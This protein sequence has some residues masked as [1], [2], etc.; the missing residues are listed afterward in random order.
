M[1]NILYGKW[2]VIMNFD[3]YKSYIETSFK[4]YTDAYDSSDTKIKLKIEHTYR[5]ANLCE[6]I[7]E[8]IG[9]N[10]KD[11]LL[12]WTCGM[13]H[14]I[15]RFEQVKR[16]GTFFDSQSVD[17]AQFGADLLFED[18]LYDRLVPWNIYDNQ[19]VIVE[20]AI[21]VHNM[22]IIPADMD[23]R[24]KMFANILRDA[25]KIDILKVNCDN[26]VN[27]VYNRPMEEFKTSFVSDDVKKA[28]N[29]KH[30][31][32]RNE[33]TSAIDFLVG[34]ICLVFELVFPMSLVIAHEQGYIY[35][36]L[37]FESDND[38]TKMWFEHMKTAV[39]EYLTAGKK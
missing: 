37:G 39:R 23:E 2:R 24:E 21:R 3:E 12:A 17:H 14:D 27:E 8:S 1:T 38:D 34:H 36:L 32:K 11:I 5:V 28:F 7:A 26:P 33:R 19:K 4:E 13:L 6:R 18:K 16:Y 30:C 9:L 15:G 20:R 10:E 29:E 35:K 22:F 25:D 31:A